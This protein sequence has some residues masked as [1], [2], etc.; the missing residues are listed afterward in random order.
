MNVYDTKITAIFELKEKLEAAKIPF[1][2]VDWK[3]LFPQMPDYNDYFEK[4]Q[5]CYPMRTGDYKSFSVIEG[6]GSYGR[7]QDLLEIMDFNGDVTG[8]LTAEQV[9]NLIKNYHEGSNKNEKSSKKN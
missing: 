1:E 4:Y 9:F 5:I 6:F 8:F 2:F 7:E 3:T